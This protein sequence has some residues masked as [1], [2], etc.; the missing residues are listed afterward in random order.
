MVK[1]HL[2]RATLGQ[3]SGMLLR[4]FHK[5][6][7]EKAT[8]KFIGNVFKLGIKVL[9]KRGF[10]TTIADSDLPKGATKDIERVINQSEN[11][12]QN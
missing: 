9:L 1:G 12:L 8:L 11:L 6:Y 3:G 7:G 5:K 10:T 4:Q 2:D